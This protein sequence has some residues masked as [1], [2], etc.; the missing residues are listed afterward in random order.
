MPD[1]FKQVF[2]EIFGGAGNYKSHYV[3]SAQLERFFNAIDGERE[4]SLETKP[5][6][7]EETL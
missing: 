4:S 3:T 1:K 5:E 6:L 2:Y 7:K